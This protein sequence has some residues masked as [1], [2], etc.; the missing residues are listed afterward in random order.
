MTATPELMGI[1]AAYQ[2]SS[3]HSLDGAIE[4]FASM[5][6]ERDASL[7][8]FATWVRCQT[9]ELLRRHGIPTF[10]AKLA[11]RV[12]ASSLTKMVTAQ[13]DCAIKMASLYE[14]HGFSNWHRPGSILSMKDHLDEVFWK[15]CIGSAP[16]Q[17]H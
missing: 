14:P 2:E 15:M 9:E 12:D 6:P 1:V 5:F 17:L 11:N 8:Q 10:A 3:G 16:W 7:S 13:V 4:A